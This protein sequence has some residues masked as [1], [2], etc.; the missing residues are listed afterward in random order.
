LLLRLLLTVVLPAVA[1]AVLFTIPL[2]SYGLSVRMS[3]T[4]P[5]VV[6]VGDFGGLLLMCNT[7]TGARTP[8]QGHTGGVS[9]LCVSEDGKLLA[10]GSNDET[11]KLWDTATGH[12]IWTSS[13]R[14][15]SVQSVVIFGDMVFCGV[16]GSNTVA[17]RKSDGTA[18]PTFAAKASRDTFGLAVVRGKERSNHFARVSRLSLTWLVS[19]LCSACSAYSTAAAGAT[20]PQVIILLSLLCLLLEPLADCVVAFRLPALRLLPQPL[21]MHRYA[22]AVCAMFPRT[23][24]QEH[25]LMRDCVDQDGDVAELRRQL[26]QRQVTQCVCVCVCVGCWSFLRSLLLRLCSS[27]AFGLGACAGGAERAS[28]GSAIDGVPL[29]CSTLTAM[30]SPKQETVTALTRD[31]AAKDS[32]IAA[33]DGVI[34]GNVRD[35]RAAQVR[36]CLQLCG[37]LTLFHAGRNRDQRE[38][39]RRAGPAAADSTGGCPFCL[40]TCSST[41]SCVSNNS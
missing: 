15:G 37:A 25:V 11:V 6:F 1:G 27:H 13:K 41:K 32:V 20:A 26:Q 8:L 5:A 10:S 29:L 31:V 24:S 30:N 9:G 16:N 33:K 38:T 12:C 28:G 40:H 2:E 19:L 18:G 36:R 22:C 14:A 4:N 23:V 34:A 17:L 35:L 21:S 7:A 3:P 39:D